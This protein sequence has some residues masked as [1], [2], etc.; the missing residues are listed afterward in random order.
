[1]MKIGG[2]VRL[3]ENLQAGDAPDGRCP[4]YAEIRDV[5]Q[6][7]EGAGFD[8]IWLADHLLYRRPGHHTRGIWECWTTLSA[9]AEAT[10]HI[11]LGTSTLCASFRNPAVLAKMAVSLDE[12]SGGRL[13]LGIGAGWNEPE[14]R[15]FG[16]PFDRRV[17]RFEEAVQIIT[18]LL[19]DGHVD[20]AGRYYTARDCELTP[21][22]PRPSGPPIL[23]GAFQPRMMR[24]A[25]RYAD[26]WNAGYFAMVD[27][28]RES[29]AS[30]EAVRT[31]V[32]PA[33]ANVAVTALLKVGW[34]DLGELPAFFG[35]DYLTG[36][37]DDIAAALRGYA[38][39]GVAHVLCQ[40]HPNVPTALDR[41]IDAVQ[42]YRRLAA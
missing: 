19:R 10:Q 29:R 25:A 15:A 9:L 7:M 4:S 27:T 31:E 36:S 28:F 8:A 37:A 38:D 2:L 21:R 12:V 42:A 33:A 26:M 34:A 6:Q 35:D 14:Y 40:Y 5:A 16:L 1:M 39:S 24:L 17:D 18:P 41:L 30:F 11:E 20:F 22:G 13:I 3:A 32:G 23:I